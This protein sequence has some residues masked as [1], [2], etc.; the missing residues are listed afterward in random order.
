MNWMSEGVLPT[1]N[2]AIAENG[3]PEVCC[4]GIVRLSDVLLLGAGILCVNMDILICNRLNNR[5]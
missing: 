3:M 2:I 5:A 1:D 4:F